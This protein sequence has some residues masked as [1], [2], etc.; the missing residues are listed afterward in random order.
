MSAIVFFIIPR[1]VTRVGT[2]FN[3][4]VL[5]RPHAALSSFTDVYLICEDVVV[6]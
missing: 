4:G 6:K 3:T 2:L 1:G 5:N